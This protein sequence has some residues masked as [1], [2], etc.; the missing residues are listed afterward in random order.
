[1]GYKTRMGDLFLD[2]AYSIGKCTRRIFWWEYNNRRHR[3][4][5]ASTE[6]RID[7]TTK[8]HN[9]SRASQRQRSISVRDMGG[10]YTLL[11]YSWHF[12]AKISSCWMVFPN[13]DG[14]SS[15]NLQDIPLRML[16]SMTIYRSHSPLHLMSS[17][18][19]GVL[20]MHTMN[21]KS[22]STHRNGYMDQRL[23]PS[24]KSFCD[25]T[26]ERNDFHVG[27]VGS[28]CIS[29]SST[30]EIQFYDKWWP[31]KV[32]VNNDV[33]QGNILGHGKWGSRY[34]SYECL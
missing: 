8:H 15:V 3:F 19:G 14:N 33:T 18:I 25:R 13:P 2:L 28:K 6:I 26:D 17:T 5:H 23:A 4:H 1:M 31:W 27:V 34:C 10:R 7:D 9:D 29:L 24:I 16:S 12:D 20:D 32:R 11:F 30:I 22:I 21:Q